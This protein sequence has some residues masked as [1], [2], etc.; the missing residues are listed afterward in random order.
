MA[1]HTQMDSLIES[2]KRLHEAQFDLIADTRH[3]SVDVVSERPAHDHDAEWVRKV[4]LNI[5]QP[6]GLT[7]LDMGDHMLGQ[8]AT[9]L[10]IPKAYFDR[11][12]VDAPGLFQTN[13]HHWLHTTP[14]RK[15]V[16][17]RHDGTIG[18]PVDIGRAWLS[19]RYR[20]LD[21][22]EVAYKLLPEL[23]N[24]GSSWEIHNASISDT[25]FHFRATFPAM[26]KAIK[27]GDPVRWGLQI[28][29]SE[30]GGAQ[31]S[32]D[33]F[34]L[35]LACINGMVVT[36]VMSARHVGKRLGENLSDEAIRADDKAFWLAARDE[37]RAS[38]SEE[39]FD[40]V[41]ATLQGATEGSRIVAPIKATET[42]AKTFDLTD[43][44]KDAVLLQLAAGGDMSRYGALNAVTAA[45]KGSESFD[46]RVEM[47]EIGWKVAELST[48]EWDRIAVAA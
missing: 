47:E 34:V 13:V 32:I 3:M 42:L 45:A 24:V 12:K 31:F 39:R 35:R 30:V 15:L 27:V 37:L 5:D 14:K 9:D 4:E 26:E 44:E 1:V 25:K 33:N 7:T 22:I 41:V 23:N 28:T 36:K 40:E 18:A 21:N 16:R 11:M 17:A 43:G 38:I 8:M 20:R 19:D 2:I 29:N 10:K 48:R 46:R 6:V